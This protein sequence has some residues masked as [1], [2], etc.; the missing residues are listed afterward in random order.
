M[1]ER[2]AV[3]SSEADV[4]STLDPEPRGSGVGKVTSPTAPG[5]GTTVR[6]AVS[7]RRFARSAVGRGTS[8]TLGP[9]AEPEEESGPLRAES[10]IEPWF[11][12]RERSARIRPAGARAESRGEPCG[13]ER[14]TRIP[15]DITRPRLPINRG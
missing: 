7:K 4:A 12:L 5:S 2:R 6:G 13:K 11:A 15:R 1:E 10:Q 8:S 9:L 14:L 3:R